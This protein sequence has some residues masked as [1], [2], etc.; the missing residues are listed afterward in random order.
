M[1]EFEI[2]A[3]GSPA[4]LRI[5]VVYRPGQPEP[6]NETEARRIDLIWQQSLAQAKRE[7]MMLYDGKLFRLERFQVDGR[8]LTLY[9]GDTTYKEYVAT[10]RPEFHQSR[11]RQH[12]AN[13]LAVCATIVTSD[14]RILV[15]R[16]RGVDVYPG[17]YHVIGGWFDRDLDG[18]ESPHPS[19]A[20]QREVREEVGLRLA[21][22]RFECLGLVYDLATPHPE[23]CFAASV[24]SRFDRICRRRGTDGEVQ[25]LEFVEASGEALRAF[26]LANHGNISAT[27]EPCLI[28]YGRR[29][30]GPDWY[31][32]IQAELR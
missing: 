11:P 23:L 17:R 13:P 10:R 9:L 19:R 14:G 12:L 3:D 25:H 26:I 6:S 15:E 22:R 16:R 27:G 31:E 21:R 2:F 8:G 7:G 32:A 20:I 24:D 4:G 28:L 5:S 29:R 30:F 1:R 18:G